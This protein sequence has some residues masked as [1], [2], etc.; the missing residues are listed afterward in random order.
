[1]K[2]SSAFF[3]LISAQSTTDTFSTEKATTLEDLAPVDFDILENAATETLEDSELHCFPDGLSLV[4][5]AKALY[6]LGFKSNAAVAEKFAIGQAWSQNC[7]FEGAANYLS[8]TDT[9][10]QFTHYYFY[11]PHGSCD[12]LTSTNDTH[13]FYNGVLRGTGG[14]NNGVIS[15][16]REY[17]LDLQ[18]DFSRDMTVSI[19]NFFTPIIRYTE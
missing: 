10:S 8:D 14:Y 16:E 4:V 7:S 2:V 15:R 13:I 1:M 3:T 11:A 5:P 19:E 12:I 9:D 17:E 6:D 18:C